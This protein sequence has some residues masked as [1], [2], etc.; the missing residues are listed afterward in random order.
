MDNKRLE[1]LRYAQ[2]WL[3]SQIESMFED[4]NTSEGST[5][6]DEASRQLAQQA[7]NMWILVDQGVDAL[8]RENI[9]LT[10]KIAAMRIALDS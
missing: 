7:K 5:P 2:G 10:N 3:S 4:A 8:T 6:V 9:V 1:N